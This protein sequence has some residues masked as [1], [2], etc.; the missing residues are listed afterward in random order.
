ALALGFLVKPVLLYAW[1]LAGGLTAWMLVR[2][3]REGGRGKG[4]APS[5]RLSGARGLWPVALA[6]L[7]PLL[8]LGLSTAHEA[9]TG[10]AEVTSLQTQNL[11]QQNA[12][13]AMLRTGDEA[14]YETT[15]A[16]LA[17]IP[18]YADRQR[19]TAEA[20]REAI[21]SRPLAYVAVH[22][23]GVAAFA[24][25]P[26]R[27]DLAVFFELPVGSSG[28][29]DESARGLGPLARFLAVQPL[30]L[31]LA[32][33]VLLVWNAVVAVAFLAWAWRGPAPPEV[34]LWCLLFVAYLA[35]VTG[36]VGSARYRLAV[37]PI[38]LLALPRAWDSLRSRFARDGRASHG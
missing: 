31:S 30:G 29:M 9:Q 28:G 26:G 33:G 36:P 6:G 19:Q 5:V 27:F 24:L 7:I 10:H 1:P 14:E 37:V 2:G 3:K 22:L 32:L 35:F 34:R 13:R 20:A 18:A 12:R 16:R 8:A 21:L 25:D 23:Q 15:D 17:V 38:L 4:G 11:W